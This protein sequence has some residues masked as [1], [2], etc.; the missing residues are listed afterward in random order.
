VNQPDKATCL[1]QAP[2]W[3]KHCYRENA[4]GSGDVTATWQPTGESQTST[5][6]NGCAIDYHGSC[7]HNEG[8]T[9]TIEWTHPDEATCFSR[10]QDWAKHCYRENAHGSGDVTATWQPT[11]ESQ[12]FTTNNGCAIDYHGS[13]PHNEGFTNTIEWTHPDEAT[14]FSRAQDWANHCYREAAHGSGDVTVTWQPTG[15]SQ[16]FTAAASCSVTCSI[17]AVS[18][19][20]STEHVTTSGHKFHRCYHDSELAATHCACECSNTAF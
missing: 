11:G 16:T 19:L 7:P 9:N 5:T 12:T 13:C 14:C 15:V 10:A 17:D 20:L 3:R 2:F 18:G 4:H 1:S 6:N 8:F